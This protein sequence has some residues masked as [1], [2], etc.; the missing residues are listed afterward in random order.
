MSSEKDEIVLNYHNSLLYRSDL[1]LLEYPNWLNDRLI[2]F[3]Y[4]YFEYEKYESRKQQVAFVNPSV[5][6]FIKLD[7]DLDEVIACFLGPLDL[8]S[9]QFIFLPIND[10]NDPENTG[11]SHWSLLFVNKPESTFMHYDSSRGSNRSIAFKLFL[12]L[13]AYFACDHFVDEPKSPQQT[14]TCDCGVYVISVTDSITNCLADANM[15]Q[16]DLS[17]ITPV[18]VKEQRSFWRD[19]I[20]KLNAK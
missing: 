4:E 16:A 9:K 3:V 19:L 10:N 8:S 15:T 18:Y 1:Q 17:S 13:K 14:N 20:S 7:G 6:Q 11:G 2:A 12:K 5:S